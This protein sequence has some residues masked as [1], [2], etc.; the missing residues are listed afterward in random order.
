MDYSFTSFERRRRLQRPKADMILPL[1]AT[2]GL[3]GM[4][5]KQIGS[6][7]DLDRDVLDELLAGMVDLGL[8]TLVLRDGVPV[9]RAVGE[10]GSEASPPGSCPCRAEWLDPALSG[11]CRRPVPR[12]CRG[13][14]SARPSHTGVAGT[15]PLRL[16]VP[17]FQPL[18]L[19]SCRED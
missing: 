19:P 7:V 13:Q 1:I 5:M 9:Y 11:R 16:A 4:T 6:A 10:I 12:R 8:L 18:P 2:S 3:T 17:V 15:A 14:T